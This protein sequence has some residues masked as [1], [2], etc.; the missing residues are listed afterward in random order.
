MLCGAYESDTLKF[1]NTQG[2]M[3]V[4]FC[5][6]YLPVWLYIYIVPTF[7][8]KSFVKMFIIV[9]AVAVKCSKMDAKSLFSL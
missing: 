4:K 6:L 1:P 5:E 2:F 9:V 8:L 3:E 7:N